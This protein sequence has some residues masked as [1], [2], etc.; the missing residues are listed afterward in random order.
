V[1]DPVF[2]DVEDVLLIHEEQLPRYGG[3]PGIRDRGLLESAVAMPRA[4]V[5]G[6]FAHEDLFAMAAAYAFHIAQN[7][8]FVDGNKRTGLLAAIVFLDLNGVEI[9]DPEGRLYDAM[10][11]IAE[12]RVEKAGLA[13]LL[14]SLTVPAARS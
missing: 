3:S 7:Q 14:E 9:A 10:L 8:P 5:G 6:D 2:L 12:R 4:T 1:T 11:G 13:G